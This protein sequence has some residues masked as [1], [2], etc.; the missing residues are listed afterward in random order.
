MA[1]SIRGCRHPGV[2]KSPPA[3][4]RLINAL[5]CHA[6]DRTFVGRC[7]LCGVV[8]RGFVVY[9]VFQNPSVVVIAGAV[10]GM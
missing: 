2:R 6:A 5:F 10:I 9:F 1:A 7:V 4:G 3:K 8:A